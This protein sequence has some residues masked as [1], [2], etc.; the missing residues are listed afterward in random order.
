MGRDGLGKCLQGSIGRSGQPPHI[1]G[2]FDQSTLLELLLGGADGVFPFLAEVLAVD[3]A[4]DAI[5]A[6][7]RVERTDIFVE[8]RG[9]Q[10]PVPCEQEQDSAGKDG[11]HGP[12]REPDAHELILGTAHGG[13]DRCA[14]CG[15]HTFFT[16]E[17]GTTC[18]AS[19][20][21]IGGEGN[22]R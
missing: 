20:L 6:K 8:D 11:V 12:A 1:V 10:R 5:I 3:N 22:E 7:V 15:V 4:V 19:G 17:R 21:C 18:G 16:L 14:Q 13:P 2:P 9:A